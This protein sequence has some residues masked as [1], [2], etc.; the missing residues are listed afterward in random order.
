MNPVTPY[1]STLGGGRDG[2]GQL[3]LS[4]WTKLTTVRGWMLTL[5][6]AVVLSAVAAML[7]ATGLGEQTS[8]DGG[9]HGTVRPFRDAG[10][11]D[12]RP[13]RGD[14]SLVARVTAQRDSQPWAKAGLMIRESTRTGAPYAAVVVT[15]RHGVRFQADFS[16]DVAGGASGAPRWLRLTRAGTTVTG[17]ESADGAAWRSVGTTELD[18]LGAAA[19]PIGLLVAS[20][21]RLE[22]GRQFGGE[23]LTESATVGAAT[24]AG[25]RLRPAGPQPSSPSF[26]DGPVTLTGS[27]D[28]GPYA[29]A[30]DSTRTALSGSMVGLLAIVALAVVFITSE[31][32][33]GML[34][35]TF[36]ASPRR[37]RVLAAKALVVGGAGFATGLLAGVAA[38]LLARPLLR[39]GGVEPASL[40]D[41]PVLRALLGTALLL[42]VVAVLGLAVGTI[43]RHSALAI[44]LLL[45][46]LLVPQ[47][48]ASGLP[49]PVAVWVERLTPA[50]GFAIQQTVPRYDAAIAP[51]AGLAVLCG[52]AAIALATAALLLRRRDA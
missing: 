26:D 16:T 12:H 36:A 43:V 33:S 51:W 1:R 37:G 22:L 41:G 6:A 25:V 47:I 40:A 21:D 34:G 45:S 3:L 8:G 50:A 44:T 39:S 28:L 38:F 2:F 13:L 19:A 9:T 10:R 49:L 14:G 27:G 20:P 48:V 30:A 5:L 18:G 15:P 11:F 23:S 52:Y 35:T 46:G 4:E 31:L 24:F 29:Y 7:L 32:R 17:Y 42:G